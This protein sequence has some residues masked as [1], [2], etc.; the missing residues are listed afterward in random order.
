[1]LIFKGTTGLLIHAD[2]ATN[3]KIKE[4]IEAHQKTSKAL[5]DDNVDFFDRQTIKHGI[6][7]VDSKV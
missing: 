1:M 3:T 6:V 5:L 7:E 4:L 2:N